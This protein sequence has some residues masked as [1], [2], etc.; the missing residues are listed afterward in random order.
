M[1]TPC[2]V[3]VSDSNPSR[4][5]PF[6]P[7]APSVRRA[8][9]VALVLVL[10]LALSLGTFLRVRGG[11]T[12]LAAPS[13]SYAYAFLATGVLLTSL[14]TSILLHAQRRR[15]TVERLV[16]R[17]TAELRAAEEELR[18]DIRRRAA[19]EQA[20]RASEERYRAFVETWRACMATPARRK[21]S[22]GGSA[23]SP[24]RMTR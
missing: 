18:G 5:E 17:R 4:G 20:L 10:G 6:D 19:A 23:K 9:P 15:A 12:E 1:A 14:L 8:L 13:T 16:A 11:D 22:D 21:S 3:S 2:A 7:A 24:R